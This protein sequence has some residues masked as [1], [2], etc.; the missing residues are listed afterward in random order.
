[1][2]MFYRI[3]VVKLSKEYLE[4]RKPSVGSE[5]Y[6]AKEKIGPLE[7]GASNTM[8]KIKNELGVVF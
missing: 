2:A 1:M 4:T 3:K 8:G 6:N 7:A 5:I